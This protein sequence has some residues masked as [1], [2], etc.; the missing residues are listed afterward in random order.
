MRLAVNIS[1]NA[2][3]RLWVAVL[4]LL[5]TPVIV[6]LL[7]PDSYGLVG[8]NATVSMFLAFLDQGV[9]PVLSRELA[10]L[11]PND[12]DGAQRARNLLR[13]SEAMSCAIAVLLGGTIILAAPWIAQHAL[14][15]GELPIGRVVAS[16]RLIGLGIATQWL[17]M[18]YSGAFMGLQRQDVLVGI[19]L[20]G[21]TLSSV[22][23]VLLLWL[24]APS[25]ELLLGWTAAIGLATSIALG[26]MVWRKM[27]VGNGHAT[28]DPASAKRLWRFAAGNLLIGFLGA[29]LAFAPGLIIAKYCTL[30]QLAAYTLSMSLAQQVTTLLTT[31]VTATLMP[32]FTALVDRRDDAALAREYHRWTQIIVALILPVAG[33]L[34]FFA[35]PLIVAWLGANSPLLEPVVELLP[36]LVVGTAFN[37]LAFMTYAL[38]VAYGWTRLIV[39]FNTC[40]IVVL[41]PLLLFFLPA[42]GVKAAAWF[43]VATNLSYYIVQAPLAHARLLPDAL[44]GWWLQDT[45][46]P[47]CVVAGVFWASSTIRTP[48]SPDAAALVQ[49]AA[50]VIVSWAFAIAALPHVRREVVRL[51]AIFSKRF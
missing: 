35:R 14:A 5:L 48:P 50:T 28:V 36:W 9:S 44:R 12:V 24:V 51:I 22:G 47:I 42:F 34:I 4:Q 31:P 46:L 1:A 26:V 18:L 38:Q 3:G 15:G 20:I 30:A 27:P 7:G 33:T 2:A 16:V 21:G 37:A 23:G 43:W 25:I 29:L 19:R 32:H 8:F 45:A 11:T 17:G 6:W 49:I 10:R 41:I 13:T 39:K 40:Q